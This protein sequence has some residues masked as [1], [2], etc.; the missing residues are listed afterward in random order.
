MAIMSQTKT[1]STRKGMNEVPQNCCSNTQT[2]CW[3]VCVR[4]C[5]REREL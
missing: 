3:G 2:V 5:E 1:G 4:V